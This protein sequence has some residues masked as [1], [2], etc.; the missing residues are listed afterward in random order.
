MKN[1]ID[2]YTSFASKEWDR[3][4]REPIEFA[5]NYH[6]I[7]HYLPTSGHILDNGA[8]PGR[9]SIE[10]AKRGYHISLTDLTPN[11][12]SMA[13]E[14]AEEYNLLH[15]FNNFTVTDA[16]DLSIY[17]DEIFDAAL[18]LGPMY[19]LQEEQTRNKAIQELHRVTKKNGFVFVAFRSRTNHAMYSLLDPEHWK[20]ND[21]INSIQEF[22]QTGVFN[23][24]DKGR[25]TGAY[26]F[27]VEDVKPFM[28]ENGFETIELL[29]STNLGALLK[30][31]A[32]ETWRDKGKEE[33]N[34]FISLLISLAKE[35]SILGISSHL[36]YIGKKK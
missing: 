13:Q 29:G 7:T 9:Y 11:F 16:Q 3:L 32:I 15:Q 22:L 34:Q 24:T 31:D 20:P 2:Y 26:F 23:H 36:L 35:P 18:M 27:N 28:E 33:Y 4:E 30:N 17:Q 25:F 8:G 6:Y 21:N 1:V 19:H 14:K 10:L 12:V 5:V